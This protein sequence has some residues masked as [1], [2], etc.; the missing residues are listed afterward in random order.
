MSCDFLQLARAPVQQ[1]S[2]Y[3]PGKPVEELARELELNPADIIKLAMIRIF[4]RM[5]QENL[6]AKMILQVHDE[7]NFNVPIEELEQVK[8]IISEEMENAV[9]LNVPL[10]TDIGVG[11]N[12]L[13]A[14]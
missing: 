4:N 14:H 11:K 9:E 5:N 12:W 1:L 8:K 6:K 10:K 13:E 7:L 2:P 3:V